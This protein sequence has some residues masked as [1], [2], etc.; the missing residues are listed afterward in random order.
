MI[1]LVEFQ[2]KVYQHTLVEKQEEQGEGGVL[3][4]LYIK[5]S[6]QEAR[7]EKGRRKR[8]LHSQTFLQGKPFSFSGK[9]IQQLKNYEKEIFFSRKWR[10]HVFSKDS[11][12]IEPHTHKMHVRVEH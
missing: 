12:S 10:K 6:R 11:N 9:F 3:T 4:L 7:K 8:L 2:H 5:C 1:P